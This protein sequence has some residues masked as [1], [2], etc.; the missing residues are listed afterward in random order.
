MP[1]M[2]RVPMREYMM[3]VKAAPPSLSD[4]KLSRRP[5]TGSRKRRSQH[6]RF[7][8]AFRQ[9]VAFRLR[10]PEQSLDSR[11]KG[12]L[13]CVEHRCLAFQ[14]GVVMHQPHRV[15]LEDH[16]DPGKPCVAPVLQSL[17]ASRGLDDISPG[18]GPAEAQ[19]HLPASSRASFL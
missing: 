14:C 17:L 3:A 1:F 9:G 10:L 13:Q 18:V 8:R 11:R 12:V 15:H 16:R 19:N 6:L 4:P 2:A 5:I 7:A